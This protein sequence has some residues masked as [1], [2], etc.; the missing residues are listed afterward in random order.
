MLSFFN[1]IFPTF[2]VFMYY[3]PQSEI[4]QPYIFKI[5]Y[6]I[7]IL[8]FIFVKKYGKIDIIYT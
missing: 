8:I 7:Y 5:I 1:Y 4:F 2:S 6:F 3:T